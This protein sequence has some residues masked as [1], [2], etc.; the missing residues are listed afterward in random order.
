MP[1]KTKCSHS[2]KLKMIY[3][4][5]TYS[6]HFISKL[7]PLTS[8]WIVQWLE[9]LSIPVVIIE[10]TKV[11][12]VFSHIAYKLLRGVSGK[13]N[14]GSLWSRLHGTVIC[15]SLQVRNH[16]H[17]LRPSCLSLQVRKHSHCLWS[18]VGLKVYNHTH[19]LWSS[20]LSP[21]VSNHTHC[22]WPL[23]NRYWQVRPT[24]T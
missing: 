4:Q 21:Q 12:S 5:R 15:L 8:L 23:W 13:V 20:C 6:M 22:L 11:T 1:F 2:E 7:L 14:C 9:V 19:C 16:T 18:G 17:C 3:C 24:L 10:S